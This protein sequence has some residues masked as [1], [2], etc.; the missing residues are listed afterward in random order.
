M[1]TVHVYRCWVFIVADVHLLVQAVGLKNS[2]GQRCK[3]CS[4]N[5]TLPWLR[6]LLALLPPQ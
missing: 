6:W 4:Y 5:H 1:H 2:L 3:L